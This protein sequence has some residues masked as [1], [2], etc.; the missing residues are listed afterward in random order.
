MRGRLDRADVR[1]TAAGDRLAD[2]GPGQVLR[3][4]YAVVRGA[5]GVVVR[6]AAD[7]RPGDRITVDVAA[8]RFSA[9]V[10]G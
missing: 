6:D 3:R 7:V 4:G 5:D 1:L 10:E 8:G 9:V 2:L